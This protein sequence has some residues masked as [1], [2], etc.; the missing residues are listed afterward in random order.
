MCSVSQQAQPPGV[1]QCDSLGGLVILGYCQVSATHRACV[2]Y[3]M[4]LIRQK[5][6]FTHDI[7]FILE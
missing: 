6:H 2:K 7:K 1:Y 5:L 3:L 4:L